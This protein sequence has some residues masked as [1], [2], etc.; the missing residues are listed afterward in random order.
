MVLGPIAAA[1]GDESA[2]FISREVHV[3]DVYVSA[4]YRRG[5]REAG[6]VLEALP[7]RSQLLVVA[8][9]VDR[10][11][12]DQLV[13]P[14]HGLTLA[15]GDTPPGTPPDWTTLASSPAPGGPP[16]SS[17]TTNPTLRSISGPSNTSALTSNPSLAT[18]HSA[19]DS[20]RS[21]RS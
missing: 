1:H 20:D 9:C 10:Y 3:D 17:K 5:K 16:L 19:S 14:I 15:R 18:N 12:L 6:G 4:D 13:N 11:L 7:E 21:C 2:A 8:V